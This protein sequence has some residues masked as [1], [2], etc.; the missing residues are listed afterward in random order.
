MLFWGSDNPNVTL[1]E[2]HIYVISGLGADHTAFSKL[3]LPGYKMVHIEWVQTI[4]NESMRDYAKRLL[5]QIKEENPIIMGLSLGGMLAVE[6]GNLIPTKKVIS[7]SS[8]I[9]YSELSFY[10][11]VA[12]WFNLYKILPIYYFSKGNSWTHWLFGVKSK[13][14]KE[15]LNAILNNL[16]PDFLSWALD[17]ILHWNKHETPSK[18]FRIHGDAD[19]V[20]FKNSKS[21]YDSVIPG[22]THFMVLVKSA[23]VSEAI[24]K[25][26]KM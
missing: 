19:K 13:A 14:D 8:I 22:G 9:N 1:M 15:I 7:I 3:N 12:S 18:L 2:Q 20:L 16:E 5:P 24:L 10:F 11:K 17:A 23:E 21:T 4:K 6:V 26:L 25:G